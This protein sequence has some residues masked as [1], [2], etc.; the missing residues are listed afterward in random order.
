VRL[1]EWME[2][3]PK[4]LQPLLPPD[5]RGFRWSARPWLVQVYYHDP[6]FHYEVWHL[7]ERRGRIEIGLHFESRDPE[8]NRDALKRM[9]RHIWEIRDRLGPYVEAELWDRGW[10][11]VFET[12]PLPP[13]D[14]ESLDRFAQRLTLWIQTL[15]PI[16]AREQAGAHDL[17]TPPRGA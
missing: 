7:G 16:L 13:L 12:H 3:L 10:A 4:R 1:R 15:E 6:A 17:P 9:S 8:R 2:A 14:E 11:K 5:L